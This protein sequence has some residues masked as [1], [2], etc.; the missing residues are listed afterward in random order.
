MEIKYVA[1]AGDKSFTKMVL[2]A[3]LEL[4]SSLTATTRCC[5]DGSLH[6]GTQMKIVELSPSYAYGPEAASA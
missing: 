1:L 6:K 3:I 4:R 2:M 5:T